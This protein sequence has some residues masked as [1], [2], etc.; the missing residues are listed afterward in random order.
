MHLVGSEHCLDGYILLSTVQPDDPGKNSLV[1]LY[2]KK[3]GLKR[4]FQ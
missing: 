1:V 3:N 4:L 2:S